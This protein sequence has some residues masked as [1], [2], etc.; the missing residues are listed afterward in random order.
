MPRRVMQGTVVSTKGNKSIVVKVESTSK[1]PLYGKT[2]RTSTKFHAHDEAN[3][4]QMGDVVEIIECS[5]RSKLKR[6]ELKSRVKIV[7]E[8][9]TDTASDVEVSSKKKAAPA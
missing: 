1:H 7:G 2:I 3:E 5:P 4:A 8:L 9:V 6:F